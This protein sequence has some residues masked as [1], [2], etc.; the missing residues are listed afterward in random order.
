MGHVKRRV[1][2]EFEKVIRT[3]HSV[4]KFQPK[5]IENKIKKILE[6]TNLAPSAGN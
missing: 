4:R 5:E 1:N 6:L 3:R 2:M